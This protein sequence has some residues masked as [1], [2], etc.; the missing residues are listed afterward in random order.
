MHS[1]IVV[2]GLQ[3]GISGVAV[4]RFHQSFR[5]VPRQIVQ[6]MPQH[7]GAVTFDAH[8]GPRYSKGTAPQI[9]LA[10]NRDHGRRLPVLRR[11][12][13]VAR[14]GGPLPSGAA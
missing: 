3:K 2:I 10:S 12:S 8:N 9:D 14:S 13:V 11:F 5:P 7:H 1:A 4:P 6:V